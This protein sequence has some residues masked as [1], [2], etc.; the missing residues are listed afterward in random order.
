MIQPCSWIQKQ[1]NNTLEVLLEDPEYAVDGR[2]HTCNWIQNARSKQKRRL[3]FPVGGNHD[4]RKSIRG[5]MYV[6]MRRDG[7]GGD[8]VDKRGKEIESERWKDIEREN[9]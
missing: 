8:D 4:V 9:M 3:L 6:S 5:E 1:Q 7:G 2:G